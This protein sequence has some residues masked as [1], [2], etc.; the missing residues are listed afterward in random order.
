MDLEPPNIYPTARSEHFETERLLVRRIATYDRDHLI[1]TLEDPDWARGFGYTNL[2]D[3]EAAIDGWVRSWDYPA[4]QTAWTFTI[5]EKA[6]EHIVGYARVQL[7]PRNGN[8]WQAMPEIAIAPGFR[9]GG[10]AYEVMCGLIAWIFD[11]LECPP[12]VKLDE[13]HSECLQSN[14]ASLG[15]LRKLSA[16]GMRDLGEHEGTINVGNHETQ[17]A[18]VHVFSLTREDYRPD[19]AT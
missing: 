16:I 6:S 4:M 11:D 5:I 14:D 18:R 10:Y 2:P 12:N 9:C 19:P 8:G 13:V 17:P 3:F 1:P 7:R 15:L